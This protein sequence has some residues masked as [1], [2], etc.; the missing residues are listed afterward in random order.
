MWLATLGLIQHKTS[1]FVAIILHSTQTIHDAIFISF[2]SVLPDRLSSSLRAEA[3]S[4]LFT[5]LLPALDQGQLEHSWKFAKI[6]GGSSIGRSY[7]IVFSL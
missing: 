4:V 5:T 3:L 2:W 7:F 6:A 1:R